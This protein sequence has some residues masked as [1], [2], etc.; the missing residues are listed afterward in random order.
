MLLTQL[1]ADAREM[2]AR[3]REMF[4]L[5]LLA[6]DVRKRIVLE[7]AALQKF[8]NFPFPGGILPC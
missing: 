5:K 2:I 4:A 1:I 3:G 6:Q 8:R 7:A